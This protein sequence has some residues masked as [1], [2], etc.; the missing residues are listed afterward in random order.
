M[1]GIPNRSNWKIGVNYDDVLED[2]NLLTDSYVGYMNARTNRIFRYKNLPDYMPVRDIELILQNY[3]FI[4]FKKVNDKIYGFFG[5]LGGM[6][7]AYYQPTKITIANPYLS[8]FAVDNVNNE[9]DKLDENDG[10][11]IWNDSAHLGLG[12]LNY[13]YA[14]LIAHSDISLKWGLVN[15]RTPSILKAK[16]DDDIKAIQEF[17]KDIESGTMKGIIDSD[18]LTSE[19]VTPISY[20]NN[21]NV[22]L[23]SIIEVRQYYWA[24]W[25]NE[26]GLQSNYNMKREAINGE[27]AGMNEEA[28][29]PLVDDMLEQRKLGIEKFNKLFGTNVEVEFNSAWVERN[30]VGEESAKEKDKEEVKVEEDN[31]EETLQ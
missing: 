29:K 27:E 31:E 28:L 17:Y 24:C 16:S 25:L 9:D 30:K 26:L 12:L 10:V 4:Y 20:Q 8:Y 6:P 14:R 3:A 19:G 7:N 21:Q 2:I 18:T 15:S 13:R 5:G 23:T 1:S 11:L 22:N